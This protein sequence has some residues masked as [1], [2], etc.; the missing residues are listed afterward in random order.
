MAVEAKTLHLQICAVTTLKVVQEAGLMV[1]VSM[2]FSFSLL[3]HQLTDERPLV[4][5]F[6][7]DL[8][9]GLGLDFLGAYEFQ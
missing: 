1:F 3:Y 4:Y 5:D 9:G 7:E 8:W 6:Q 2:A